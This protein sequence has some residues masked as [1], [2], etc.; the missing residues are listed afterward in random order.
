MRKI[1]VC[2]TEKIHEFEADCVNF[3]VTL[4]IIKNHS[5]I[6]EFTKWEYW[7]YVD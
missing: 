6:A 5:L 7:K 4:Q 3:E 1:I 2:T